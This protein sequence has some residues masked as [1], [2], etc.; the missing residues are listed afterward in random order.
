MGNGYVGSAGRNGPD[1][2]ILFII[3]SEAVYRSKDRQ[4]GYLQYF[5]EYFHM[6][7]DMHTRD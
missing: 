1:K 3:Y 4:W 6:A 5:L 7:D 2:F